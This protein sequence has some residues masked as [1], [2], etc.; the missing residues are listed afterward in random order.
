MACLSKIRSV[1]SDEQGATVSPTF[2]DKKC[3]GDRKMSALHTILTGVNCH[4][5]RDALDLA[6]E[7]RFEQIKGS[8]AFAHREADSP[9]FDYCYDGNRTLGSELG[10]RFRQSFGA[11]NPEETARGTHDAQIASTYHEAA[12]AEY[13]YRFEKIW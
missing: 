4:A 8:D 10:W 6:V 11:L 7:R 12:G 3:K 2:A 9:G 13:H 1:K 5:Q